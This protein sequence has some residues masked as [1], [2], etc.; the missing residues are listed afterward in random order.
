M[1]NTQKVAAAK[2]GVDVK[3]A[4]KYLKSGKL[5]SELK[6]P[7]DWQTRKDPFAKDWSWIKEQIIAEPELEA[8]ALLE[9]LILKYPDRYASKHL[10]T[11]QRRF[12]DTRAKSGK[13]QDVKFTQRHAPGKQSQVDFTEMNELRVTINGESFSHLL[14]HLKLSYSK[15]EWIKICF[16]ESHENGVIEKSHDL[17]KRAV[18]QALIL[19]GSADFSSQE[20][21][22]GFLMTVLDK[23]NRGV[24]KA[25]EREADHLKPLPQDKWLAP[26]ITTA[27]VRSTSLV[28]IGKVQY[29]VPS[30]LIGQRLNVYIYRDKIDVYYKNTFVQS[31]KKLAKGAD[32]NYRH[33]VHSLIK[34]PGAFHNYMYKGFLFPCVT[35]RRAYEACEKASPSL[36][37]KVYLRILELA[38]NHG[39]D[40]V[41]VVL[42]DLLSQKVTLDVA[43]VRALLKVEQ[44]VPEVHVDQPDL[45]SYDQL[46]EAA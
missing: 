35:F 40:N 45:T 23:R 15:W 28:E 33:V 14:F 21:Y 24:A 37:H 46:T 41:R 11:L 16:S 17:F 18:K 22:E 5:P 42:E 3:T 4:R 32:I 7:H 1:K 34:K 8:K 20:E 25:L 12:E 19:R 38:K 6:K 31:M 39:E 13:D 9:E 36:G 10:R 29:S 2:S 44:T 30:R 26:K 27:K 43:K